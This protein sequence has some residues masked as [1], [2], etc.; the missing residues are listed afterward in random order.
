LRST[1]DQ[2]VSEDMLRM[3]VAEA[4]RS[5]Q[6]IESEEG[7]MIKAVLDMQDQRVTNIMQPRVDVV[8][9]PIESPAS[10]ILRTFVLTKYSRIPIYKGDIDNIVGVVLCKNLLNYMSLSVGLVLCKNLLNYMSLS[11]KPISALEEAKTP[12]DRRGKKSKPLPAAGGGGGFD[13]PAAAIPA[14]LSTPTSSEFR[15]SR[16]GPRSQELTS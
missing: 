6:G 14:L 4:E 7:R 2:S 9:L 10:H 8:A 3:V 15:W 5:E 11:D 13:V 16:V 12:A 1:E